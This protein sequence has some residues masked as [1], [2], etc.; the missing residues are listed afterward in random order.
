MR[1]YTMVKKNWEAEIKASR[2]DKA[3]A[4]KPRP[5]ALKPPPFKDK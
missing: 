3:E 1:L 5:S 2:A 4:R